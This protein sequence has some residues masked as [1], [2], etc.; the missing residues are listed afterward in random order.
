MTTTNGTEASWTSSIT[1][2]SL[3]DGGGSVVPIENTPGV[4]GLILIST[5]TGAEWQS[6]TGGVNGPNNS[7]DNQVARFDSTSGKLIKTSD[8]VIDDDGK[9]NNATLEHNS[10]TVTA[11]GIWDKLGTRVT[12]NNTPTV[13]GQGLVTTD[14]SNASWATVGDVL[15]TTSPTTANAIATF[16]DTTGKI[17]KQSNSNAS[18]ESNGQINCIGLSSTGNI[19]CNTS[20]GQINHASFRKGLPGTR[21]GDIIFGTATAANISSL[22]YR[23][24]RLGA[25]AVIMFTLRNNSSDINALSPILSIEN[26]I[27]SFNQIQT[28]YAQGTYTSGGVAYNFSSDQIYYLDGNESRLDLSFSPNWTL[29]GIL[30]AIVWIQNT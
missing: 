21:I 18:I 23:G 26:N 22:S 10:N 2:T 27:G 1:A 24:F 12:V 20:D 7:L 15:S 28:G 19:T 5:A 9:I 17:I 16:D 4:A 11:D 3:S 6:G 13:A 29:N 14:A 8:V 25:L 30:N